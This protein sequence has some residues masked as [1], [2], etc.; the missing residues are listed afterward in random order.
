VPDRDLRIAYLERLH[1]ALSLPEDERLAAIEEI[2]AHLY[3]AGEELEARGIPRDVATRQVLERLGGPDRLAHDLTAAHRRPTHVLTAAGLALRISVVTGF[4]AFIMA[5]AAAF[6]AA[7][8][9]GMTVTGIRRLAGPGFLEADWT[10][11]LDGLLPAMVTAVVA[12]A[13]GSAI[14]AP[15]ALAARRERD[16]VRR[17][18]LIAGIALASIIGLTAVEA[19]WSLAT[20]V[21]MA[22]APA[23]Y[24]LG[25][26]RPNLVS[27]SLVPRQRFLVA[28]A[29]LG[30]TLP[31]VVL[32][33]GG[34]V[35]TTGESLESEAYDPNVA[36]AAVGRFV[37]IENPPLEILESSESAGPFAG[38]G[39]IL[40]ERSGAFVG[41]ATGEWTDLRLEVWQGPA[42][43]LNGAALDPAAT[44]PLVTAPMIVSGSRVHGS[45]ELLPEPRRSFYYVAITGVA[46]DGERV[47]LAWPGV[48]WWQ[49]RG[50]AL[51]FFEALIR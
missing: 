7:L 9:L 26:L 50:T 20:A 24:T 44:E 11:L 27:V 35:V 22:S 23:W 14:V 4:K 47:Q 41:S 8:A 42:D 12:F 25:V 10:P 32:Q 34:V 40:I 37:D 49:W 38:A 5:W 6:I 2:D 17:P 45:V 15:V 39:P 28:V 29:A 33:L 43:E 16:E 36:Y 21:A 46:A 1:A 31:I 30:L 48:E 18:L 3:L 13:V 51:Q 19:R